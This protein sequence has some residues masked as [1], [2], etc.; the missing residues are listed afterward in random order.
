MIEPYRLML[1]YWLVR[2]TL[3]EQIVFEQRYEWQACRDPGETLDK[4]SRG[5]LYIIFAASCESITISK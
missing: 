4:G 5:L 2:K 3:C 1:L